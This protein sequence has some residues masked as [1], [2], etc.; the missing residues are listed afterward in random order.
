MQ[1]NSAI[2]SYTTEIKNDYCRM[3][4]SI[5]IDAIVILCKKNPA[6]C[7]IKI[8]RMSTQFASKNHACLRVYWHATKA[9]SET[10]RAK[11]HKN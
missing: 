3:D 10:Q 6:I 1:E 5:S 11:S 7:L 4:P 2:L 8:S 9:Q